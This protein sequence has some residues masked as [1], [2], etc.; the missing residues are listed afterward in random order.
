MTEER[1]EAICPAVSAYG[2]GSKTASAKTAGA[3]LL[4]DYRISIA[5]RI[6]K[7]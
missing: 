6:G 4:I 1:R 7:P 3:Y 5:F 2:S